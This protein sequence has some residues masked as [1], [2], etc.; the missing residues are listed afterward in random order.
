MHSQKNIVSDNADLKHSSQQGILTGILYV[1][2]T[3]RGM[4][5]LLE[6]RIT[7][8]IMS[9]ERPLGFYL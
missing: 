7:D 3:D 6:Y 5:V 4:K 2:R 1:I 9:F 8:T